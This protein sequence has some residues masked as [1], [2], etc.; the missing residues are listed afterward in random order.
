MTH[1]CFNG[2]VMNNFENKKNLVKIFI[3]SL[4]LGG[5]TARVGKLRRRT[6]KKNTI[7]FQKVI[8]KNIFL[9]MRKIPALKKR[10]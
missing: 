4:L 9:K 5:E 2:A 3:T 1:T 8:S 7:D 10:C 6:V